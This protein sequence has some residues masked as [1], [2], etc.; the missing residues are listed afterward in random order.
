MIA[1][2][3]S[4]TC[5]GGF[6]SIYAEIAQVESIDVRSI[7]RSLVCVTKSANYDYI[8]LASRGVGI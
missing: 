4:R 3:S 8:L 6:E 2:P 7:T 1:D 5:A